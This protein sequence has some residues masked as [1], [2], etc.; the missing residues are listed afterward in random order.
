MPRFIRI[1]VAGLAVA[2][3]LVGG[4][5]ATASAAARLNTHPTPSAC[6]CLEPWQ[7]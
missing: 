2:A 7:K 6:K 1:T 3:A 4:T 5:G